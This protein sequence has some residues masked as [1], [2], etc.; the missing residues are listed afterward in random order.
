MY[1]RHSI[2]G[3]HTLR[4][5]FDPPKFEAIELPN[6]II[7]MVD[8]DHAR[9]ITTRCSCHHIQALVHSVAIDWKDEQQRCVALHS[10]DSK[11]R[12]VFGTVKRGFPLQDVAEFIGFPKS[13]LRPSQIFEDS[14][15]CI[16]VLEANTV[17]T[18]VKHIAV[19]IHFI[20]D[21]IFVNYFVMQKI[22]T[23]LNLSDLGTK[24]NPAPTHFCQYDHTSGVRFCPPK[25]S[26]HY[27]LISPDTFLA[28]PY[29]ST[30]LASTAMPPQAP[31]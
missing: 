10:T 2:E 9:D 4:V 1:P 23:N 30:N 16:D 19:P 5:D 27:V 24:P 12:G 15:P 28:S 13:M 14:Q 3:V 22:G 17:T 11:I 21:Q 31:I 18:R 20:H 26:E 7:F 6:G 25:D 29:T 8:S